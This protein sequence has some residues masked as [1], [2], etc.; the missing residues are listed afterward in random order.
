MMCVCVN[1]LLQMTCL[2][3]CA[4]YQHTRFGDERGDPP[5]G[6]TW[7]KA[8]EDYIKGCQHK[9]DTLCDPDMDQRVEGEEEDTKTDDVG[10][11]GQGGTP[12]DGQSAK[13]SKH[14]SQDNTGAAQTIKKNRPPIA[15]NKQE[16]DNAPIVLSKIGW[17]QVD[18]KFRDL[19]EARLTCDARAIET[20]IH[21]KF[22]HLPLGTHPPVPCCASP[23]SLSI[24]LKS[25]IRCKAVASC[26]SWVIPTPR[27][28]AQEFP[29]QDRYWLGWVHNTFEMLE[30][31]S[32]VTTSV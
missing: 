6:W 17:D 14:G 30:P 22:H 31:G 24:E 25:V 21:K 28:R 23:C 16:A 11:G 4:Y 19:F 20:R 27:R 5:P 26:G 18:M 13:S 32:M 10:E 9:K 3:A 15:L 1:I 12:S 2:R 29:Q 8:D 7:K